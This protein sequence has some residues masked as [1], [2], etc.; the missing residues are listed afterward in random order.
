MNE[1]IEGAGEDASDEPSPFSMFHTIFCWLASPELD[2]MHTDILP[3]TIATYENIGFGAQIHII[4]NSL[5]VFHIVTQSA[6]LE[7]I[8]NTL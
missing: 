5:P 3:G 8:C 6:L 4:A 1:K 7:C 2:C